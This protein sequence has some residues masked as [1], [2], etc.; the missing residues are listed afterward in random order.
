MKS[1]V[2][3]RIKTV[4]LVVKGL[5]E[6]LKICVVSVTRLAVLGRTCKGLRMIILKK[7]LKCT[8]KISGKQERLVQKRK[9]KRLVLLALLY[10]SSKFLLS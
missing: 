10:S 2:L 4:A 6:I 1:F 5:S 3:S 7:T 8:W 9:R